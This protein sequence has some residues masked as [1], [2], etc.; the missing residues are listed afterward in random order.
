MAHIRGK[1]SGKV[2]IPNA[3]LNMDYQMLT[4]QADD[5]YKS[6]IDELDKRLERMSPSEILKKQAEIVESTKTILAAKP[7]KM[8]TC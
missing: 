1:F 4:A 7:L 2:A 8:K 3:E 5:E 6:T